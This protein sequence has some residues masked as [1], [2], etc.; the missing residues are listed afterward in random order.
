MNDRYDVEA[1]YSIDEFLQKEK[2]KWED[3][4]DDPSVP[5]CPECD[6]SGHMNRVEHGHYVT[7]VCMNC[8][9]LY[10]DIIHGGVPIW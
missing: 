7:F 6:D 8:L 10:E 2:Q 3:R 4:R 9:D 5:Q 1:D